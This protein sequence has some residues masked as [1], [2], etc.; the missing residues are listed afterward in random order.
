MKKLISVLMCAAIIMAIV[1]FSTFAVTS[2][3]IGKEGNIIWSFDDGVLTISGTGNMS[4]SFSGSIP[5]GKDDCPAW[6]DLDFTSVIIEEG[7][8]GVNAFAFIYSEK[9]ETISF[10]SSM[11]YLYNVVGYPSL[12]EIKLGKNN[13]YFTLKHGVLFNEDCTKII[14]YPAMREGTEYAIPYGVEC[15]GDHALARSQI[16]EKIVIPDTVK[17]IENYAFYGCK[18]IQEFV[19]PGSVTYIGDSALDSCESLR[20]VN[21]PAGVKDINHLFST[22]FALERVIIEGKIEKIT[23]Y[24][25]I[26]TE[27]L[28]DIYF[29]GSEADKEKIEIGN[30]NDCLDT[31]TWHFNTDTTSI[32]PFQYKEP[33]IKD[34]ILI[35]YH[36]GRMVCNYKSTIRLKA[37]VDDDVSILWY[38][39]GKPISNEMIVEIKQVTDDFT[40][41]I[42]ATQ[43]NGVQTRQIQ[44]Y[45]VKHGFFDKL[46]WFIMHYFYPDSFI[47]D[48]T[49]GI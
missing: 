12:K 16:L 20:S 45:G 30:F 25:F 22:D 3:T 35:L 21:I 44:K 19:I 36:D 46:Y 31:A 13:E 2:G 37:D 34:D 5:D 26:L 49:K 41:E 23:D 43:K 7:V 27:N 1:P 24:S 10:P 8:T 38:L 39:N 32:P 47:L 14:M 15:I 42:V 9:L 11:Q 48:F 4:Y 18:K 17:I 6:G 33:E 28:K 40:V 29:A